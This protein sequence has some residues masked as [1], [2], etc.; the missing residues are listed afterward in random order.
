[1]S[2][3][4]RTFITM[5]L[6]LTTTVHSA[7]EIQ[8]PPADGRPLSEQQW[9]QYDWNASTGATR[10]A[11]FEIVQGKDGALLQ[12][13][14]ETPN[15]ARFVRELSVEPD[16]VYRL[17]CLARSENVG[18]A[19]R[20]AGISVAEIQDGSPDIKGSSNNW[21]L[22]ELFGKTG[23]DQKKLSVTV[24]IGG[25][26]SLNSG[27]VQFRD[28]TV[29]KVSSVPAGIRVASL[30]PPAVT[31]PAPVGRVHTGGVVIAA[32]GCIGALLAWWGSI[33]RR[34]NSDIGERV[35]DET[36]PAAAP[37]KKLELGDVTVMAVLSAACLIVSLF[38]LGGHLAPETGWQ[39]TAAGE[40]VTINLGREVDLSRIYYYCGINNS[41]G[42]GSQYSIAARN[43]AGAFVELASFNKDDVG[44]WKYSE[45]AV[46]TSAV[47]L[48]AD[49]PGGRFNEI[50]FVEKGSRIPLTDLKI[51][52][53]E[54]SGAD[55]GKTKN[56]IDE[57]SSFEYAPSF[58]TGFYF[59]EIYHAR[60]AWEMLHRI[61]PYETTHPPL[62]KLLISSGIAVFGMNP[63]GW[64]V[65]GALFGVALVP[66]MYL[67]GLKLFRNRYY[68]FCAAFLMMVEFMRF[69]QSRVA[70]IDV[71]GVFFILLMYYFILDLFP[72]KGEGPRRNTNLTLL[73]AGIAFG[74]GAACKW[75]ALYAGC[76][77]VLLVVLRTAAELRQRNYSAEHGLAGFL[78]RRIGICLVAFGVLPALIY[79][80]AFLPYLAL[81]GPGHDLTDVFRLQAHMLNYHRTLQATHPFS[82]PWW[83]WPLDLH[84]MWMY[85]GAG[86]PDGTAS[87]IVSFGNP[88][89][90][91]LGIPAVATAAFL[92]LR[93]RDA[94]LG[95]VLTALVCQYLPWVGINRLAFIYHFFSTV[96]FLILCIVATLRSAELRCPRFRAVTWGYLGVA[97]GLFILFYPVLSGLQVSQDY[98]ASLRW[99]PTW[100]F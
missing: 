97:A 9:T 18:S 17:A 8:T 67:F 93:N 69:A 20:G 90:F 33:I 89:I 70:V 72:E 38:N 50:A 11:R 71:Y 86:L 23:S 1:M 59:D 43:P 60:T 91:W 76:G 88:A 77:M 5:L 24:G 37:V 35:P 78:L 44:V 65:V 31:A 25:Y 6:L 92:A 21:Q 39:S 66:L 45:V 29:E 26:G 22:L 80:S 53:G 30:Q 2:C 34:R 68:A 52:E 4:V 54:L 98:V 74:I 94:R 3:V 48:T 99:F 46:R 75:I 51:V 47:R 84:P 41:S 87:S 100:F 27:M 82:S 14:A 40:S 19:A 55:R 56:L 62:G 81:P 12:I 7:E 57:Q 73:L 49:T 85:T 64:R 36:V 13:I 79:L 95:V 16:T 28:V 10:A 61:E 15:D 42:D 83:S 96:P 58:Q 32:L 63:F